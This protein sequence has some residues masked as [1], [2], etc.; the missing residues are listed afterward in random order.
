MH[1][2]TH[3]FTHSPLPVLEHDNRVTRDQ[4]VGAY[5]TFN[6]E[7]DVRISQF[8]YQ[9][10]DLD[11]Q[12]FASVKLTFS[13]DTEQEVS[14]EEGSGPFTVTLERTGVVQSVTITVLT[15]YPTSDSGFSEIAFYGTEE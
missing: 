12:W 13:D 6:F 10:R 3:P 8:R 1:A 5:V 4:G 14:L 11:Y 7:R 9:Q 15:G 2:R